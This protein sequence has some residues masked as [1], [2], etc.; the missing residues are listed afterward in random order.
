MFPFSKLRSS[1]L[2]HTRLCTSSRSSAMHLTPE[3]HKCEV[4]WMNEEI[5]GRT[6]I[7]S[8]LDGFTE[9]KGEERLNRD[10]A[11]MTHP[12]TGSK[13]IVSN[14]E[15]NVFSLRRGKRSKGQRRGRRVTEKSKRVLTEQNKSKGGR[16]C[17]NSNTHTHTHTH[18]HT[19]CSVAQVCMHQ[20]W[21]DTCELKRHGCLTVFKHLSLLQFLFSSWDDF[22]C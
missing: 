11:N 5:E 4:D 2:I 12:W 6:E 16:Q 15:E 20:H 8:I 17:T 7:P 21:D 19:Q 10:G 3:R 1:E 22:S 13:L 9:R 18:T 14:R